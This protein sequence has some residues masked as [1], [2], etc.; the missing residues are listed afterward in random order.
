MHFEDRT[1]RSNGI[2]SDSKRIIT[3]EMKKYQSINNSGVWMVGLQMIVFSVPS[4]V[5]V[6]IHSV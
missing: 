2:A 5:H 1:L 3:F 4:A 6:T